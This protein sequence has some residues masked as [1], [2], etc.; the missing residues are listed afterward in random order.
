MLHILL[1]FHHIK[2]TN[3]KK[4]LYFKIL[5]KFFVKH[6]QTLSWHAPSGAPDC[7]P[8]DY[9][10]G[11]VRKVEI[12]K[13]EAQSQ[14][15]IF[16]QNLVFWAQTFFQAALENFLWGLRQRSMYLGRS[17]DIGLSSARRMMVIRNVEVPHICFI[18]H[19]KM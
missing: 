15:R 13:N 7:S 3:V 9:M 11:K 6:F 17:L 5:F 18:Y 14:A 4:E 1:F 2:F 8:S 16:W 10:S 19:A 12:L